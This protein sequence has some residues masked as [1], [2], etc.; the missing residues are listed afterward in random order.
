MVVL[1]VDLTSSF[2]PFTL[3]RPHGAYQYAV[4]SPKPGRRLTLYRRSA[5][6]AR[7]MIE[8]DPVTRKFCE[9]SG[10]IGV[11]GHRCVVDFL[12]GCGDRECLVFLSKPNTGN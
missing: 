11:D 5:L 6:D 9:R 8:S 3:P 2:E 4:F 10:F 1:T 7:L 12:V